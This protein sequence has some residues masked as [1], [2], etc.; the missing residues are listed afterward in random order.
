MQPNK[1][2]CAAVDLKGTMTRHGPIVVCA[3]EC[4][5][6]QGEDADIG[7]VLTWVAAQC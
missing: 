5:Q 6:K 4:R 1:V 2:K 7:P 3:A